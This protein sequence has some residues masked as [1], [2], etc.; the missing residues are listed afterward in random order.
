[1]KR[2]AVV[3]VFG[4]LNL[5]F[6]VFGVFGLIA[7]VIMFFIMPVAD[8]NNPVLRLVHDNPAYASWIK[9]T[10]GLGMVGIAIELAAGIGLLKLKPWG[11]Q[12]A[13]VF[14]IFSIFV[15][16]VGMV[17]NYFYMMRPLIEQAQQQHGP[18]SAVA[19]GGAIGGTFGSCFGMVYPVLLLVFMLRPN[20]AAA[21]QPPAAAGQYSGEPPPDSSST[22][23]RP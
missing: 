14:A 10:L 16:V 1:M 2:P 12:L 4:I 20:V 8:T 5:V 6:A 18:E 11:R 9:L 22:D 21:F 17:G 19:M 15:D 13:I 23:G 3:T 7:S